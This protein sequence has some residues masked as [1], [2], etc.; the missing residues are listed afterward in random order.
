MWTK[1]QNSFTKWFVRKFSMYHH[2]T[3]NMLLY[4]VKFENRKMLPNFYVERDNFYV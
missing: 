3:Y 2:L 4:L 1:F